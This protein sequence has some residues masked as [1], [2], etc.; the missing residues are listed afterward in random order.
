[1][2]RTARYKH[3]GPLVN[4]GREKFCNVALLFSVFGFGFVRLQPYLKTSDQDKSDWHSQIHQQGILN[5]GEEVSSQL[6]SLYLP[7]RISCLF[8]EDFYFYKTIFL[9]Q[10][11]NRTEPSR[12]VRFPW[13]KLITSRCFLRA[14]VSQR[15]YR[16]QLLSPQ[17]YV[18]EPWAVFTTL[19]FLRN[20]RRAQ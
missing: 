7:A 11:F 15:V 4:Y 14:E 18:Q 5:E 1:M 9:D 2:M 6:T 13:H 8:T 20:L 10:E 17:S 3:L 19:C 12:S 16:R